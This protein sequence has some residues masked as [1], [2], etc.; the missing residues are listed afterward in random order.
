ME[1][2][3]EQAKSLICSN[4][5]RELGMFNML[6]TEEHKG[7]YPCQYRPDP[8]PTTD[9]APWLWWLPFLRGWKSG[10]AAY[11]CMQCP[12]TYKYGWCD[13]YVPG[14][15]NPGHYRGAA[16]LGLAGSMIRWFR[17]TGSLVMAGI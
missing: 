6:Y 4:N 16:E 2:A 12:T 11:Q 17:P 7:L 9:R 3:S 10:P 14:A 5:L 8:D 1:A 13:D 15:V